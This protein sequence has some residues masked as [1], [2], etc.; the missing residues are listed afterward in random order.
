MYG[1][2]FDHHSVVYEFEN[3]QRLVSNCRQQ[4]GCS[5]RSASFALGSKGRAEVSERRHVM[6]GE[7]RWRFKGKAKNMYQVE[8]DEL[9]AGIRSGN[10]LNNGEYMAKSTLLAIMGRMATYTGKEI[11]WDQALSSKEDLSPKR[12]AWGEAP[13]VEIAMPGITPFA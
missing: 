7:A 5:N 1:N 13:E 11:S 6:E 3:G 9:F 2:I 12:Y 10:P 8:H 4:K